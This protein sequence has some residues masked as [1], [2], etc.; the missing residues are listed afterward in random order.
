MSE[1]IAQPPVPYMTG[2]FALYE[3]PGGGRCI[4]YRPEGQESQQIMIPA[5]M[6]RLIERMEQGDRPSLM[7][8]FKAMKEQ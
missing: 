6:M 4:A 7:E 1:A 3:T 8:M 5:P 2:T